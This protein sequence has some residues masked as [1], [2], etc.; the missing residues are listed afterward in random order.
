MYESLASGPFSERRVALIHGRIPA[1]ERDAI[2]RDFRD[3]KIDILV[4]TTVIEVGIDVPNA[5][6]MLIEHPERFG[7]SQLHQLRGRVGRGAEASYCILLGDV[8][9]EA[10]DR[11]RIFVETEDGF[12]IARADLKM[13]GMGNLF[14]QEQSGIA[15]FRIADP[16]RDERLGVQAR[17]AAEELLVEDP[18]LASQANAGIRKILSQ[19]YARALELFRIG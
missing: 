1:Q 16:I 6:V 9:P 11:L 15:G 13:R 7:L 18:E 5:T 12:E 17:V 8:S 19:R 3:G 10:A 14:G 2:M 4:A